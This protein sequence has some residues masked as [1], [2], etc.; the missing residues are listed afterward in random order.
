MDMVDIDTDSFSHVI[1]DRMEN[2]GR[3]VQIAADAYR[4]QLQTQLLD[5]LSGLRDYFSRIGFDDMMQLCEE[6]A[7]GKLHGKVDAFELAM[8][9][10]EWARMRDLTRT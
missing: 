4:N 8:A 9:L 3:Q 6:L 5:G 7:A 2:R 10:R 1:N